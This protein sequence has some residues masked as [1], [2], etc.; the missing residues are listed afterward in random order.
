MWEPQEAFGAKKKTSPIH[1][2]SKYAA[3]VVD[4]ATGKV[5]YSKN[6]HARRYPASLTKKMTL[7]LI[8]EALEKG[9]ITLDTHWNVSALAQN[10]MPSRLGLK[11]GETISVS[12]VIKALITKSANDSAVVAAEGLEGSVEGFASMMNKKA[13]VL[14]MTNT[15]FT[16]PSGVPDSR[17]TTTAHDMAI[18]GRALH[19]D[20]PEY[21]KLFKLKGFQYK[22]AH[23][24]NHNHM[25]DN[26]EGLD[27]IKTG[28]IGASGFNISTSTERDNRR[29]FTVVMGGRSRH[30][31]DRHAKELIETSF[32]KLLN[33]SESKFLEPTENN[34]AA[35]EL[36][37]RLVEISAPPKSQKK[38]KKERSRKKNSLDKRL[39]TLMNEPDKKPRSNARLSPTGIT[40]IAKQTPVPSIKPPSK[41]LPNGWVIPTKAN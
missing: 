8:F 37:G 30:D 29:I 5:L 9:K 41:K 13:S 21:Y 35:L 40:K 26:V 11:A 18:L 16:N 22:G 12:N 10:Q 32:K 25:L 6:A 4:G 14:G 34:L 28:Y 20:Y 39:L 7:Y 3:I 19:R 2:S 24:R 15:H 17:Q 36:E 31:R 1:Q 33:K 38:S 23:H 27:G